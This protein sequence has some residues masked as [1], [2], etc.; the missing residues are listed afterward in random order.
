MPRFT[1]A[2]VF[3]ALLALPA[4]ASAITVSKAELKAGQLVVEG[5]NAAPGIFVSVES[6]TSAAGKR[7][8]TSGRFKVAA[9]GFT[10]PDCDVV[11][12]DRQTPTATVRL[13]GCTPSITPPPTTLPPPSGTCVIDP[14]APVAFHAGDASVYN[15]TTTGCTAGPLQWKV[16][17]GAIP[18]G[19]SGPSFQGQTAGNIIGTPTLE[20]TYAF[21]LQATDG[22]GATDRKTFTITVTAPRP[23]TITTPGSQPA[24]TVGQGYCCVSLA[25]D[26]GVPGYAWTLVSGTLPPGLQLSRGVIGGT[27]TTRG[28]FSFT[29]RATDSRATTA[30]RTLSITIA[31]LG[32]GK[33]A[34]QTS[35]PGAA[36][37]EL[38][39]VV[40]HVDDEARV[41]AGPRQHEHLVGQARTDA[42]GER[43]LAFEAA[44]VDDA[45][46]RHEAGHAGHA[47]RRLEGV[48]AGAGVDVVGGVE[49][50]DAQQRAGR[51]LHVGRERQPSTLAV[52]LVRVP[53]AV[54]ACRAVD[55]DDEAVPARLLADAARDDRRA[56]HGAARLVQAAPHRGADRRPRGTGEG[57]QEAGEQHGGGAH[58]GDR[59]SH[60]YLPWCG[61]YGNPSDRS[62][63]RRKRERAQDQPSASSACSAAARSRPRAYPRSAMSA[64]V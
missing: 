29:V 30:G 10:A 33:S 49:Q 51:A 26:G 63:Y 42:E 58:G 35:Q 7:S 57:G 13:S 45:A 54:A 18:T 6:T 16:V 4:S 23:L 46:E 32:L 48:R 2:I 43:R 20:G 55:L 3:V 5:A 34:P 39:P 19:M 62:R 24:G 47:L 59:A 40:T 12:S 11:V 37:L 22:T 36:A 28:T 8:D 1:V 41:G 61:L 38:A 60:V 56:A 44:A 9:S 64:T 50:V 15:F 14:A 52:D 25:A 21:T 17:A 31:W 27:P 53:D